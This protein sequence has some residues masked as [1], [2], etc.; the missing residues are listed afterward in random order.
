VAVG[1]L[2]FYL[3]LITLIKYTDNCSYV[4]WLGIKYTKY[5]ATLTAVTDVLNMQWVPGALSLGVK[6][7]GREAEQ[8]PPS[9]AEV[10]E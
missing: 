6:R 8:S 1:I 7:P 5:H 10:K 4:N 2:R 3:L 9:S